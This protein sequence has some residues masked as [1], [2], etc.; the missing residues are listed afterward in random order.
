MGGA[1]AVHKSRTGEDGLGMTR[2]PEAQNNKLIQ[3]N[4]ELGQAFS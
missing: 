1:R 2:H 4:L 3:L